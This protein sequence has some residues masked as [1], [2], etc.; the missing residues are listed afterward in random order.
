[1]IVSIGE[2]TLTITAPNGTALTHWSLPAV[3]RLNPREMPAVYGPGSEPAETL[4]LEDSE[5]VAAI[6]RVLSALRRG[7]GRAR[8]ISRGTRLLVLGA[9]FAALAFWLPGAISAY[10][11]RLVPD[12]AQAQIGA[13]LLAETERV[14]GAPCSDPDGLR[15]LDV[16]AERLF[17][18][19]GTRLVVFPS[20]LKTSAHVPGGTILLSHTLVE[21]YETPD[22]VAGF[23]LAEDLRAKAGNSL[24]T[25]LE[26]SPFR[27]SLALLSTGRLREA[28]LQ[29]MAEWLIV[30]PND[31]VDD[32][33]LI[34][35]IER[36]GISP[37]PYG[38][39]IDISA[40]STSN[41]V[42]AE[43]ASDMPILGDTAWLALQAIC[44]E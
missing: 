35:A 36:R 3:V 42:A 12:V 21:D 13:Q 27:A 33:A 2:A 9:A 30:K 34:A 38:Y 16:L 14:A 18:D 39:A 25:L 43:R 20:T 37:A 8:W 26:A 29:R 1:M 7:P 19:D 31:P 24:G 5:L 23:A 32:S 40:E 17:P 44:S 22:V 6:D 28:D 11:A 41:F 15:A 10:T 4:E